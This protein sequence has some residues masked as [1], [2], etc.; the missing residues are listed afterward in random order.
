[1]SHATSSSSTLS[2]LATGAKGVRVFSGAQWVDEITLRAKIAAEIQASTEEDKPADLIFVSGDRSQVGKSSTCLGLLATLHEKL[3]FGAKELAYIKPATQCEAVQLV[4][5][6]ALEHHI[7]APTGPVTY[8]SGFTREF[9]D[10]NTKTTEEMLQDIFDAVE[11]LRRTPGRRLVV[12]DGVGYPAVGSICGLSN[13]AMAKRIG[14]PVVL[15]CPSGVGN[16]IDSFNLNATF[17]EAHGVPVLGGLFNRFPREGF[18]AVDKASPS[19][20]S[21]F[22]QYKKKQKAYACLTEIEEL[23]ELAKAE[24]DGSWGKAQA[25]AVEALL[26]TIPKESVQAIIDDAR[27]A[28]VSPHEW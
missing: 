9:L 25:A 22:A 21:Y 28:L 13:A 20:Y 2:S 1:M 10:G 26:N 14:A 6:Y 23:K 8:V 15:V 16:A 18:Y 27:V 4:T 24:D 3:G 19:I 11:A 17:F 7:D 5:R 12:V